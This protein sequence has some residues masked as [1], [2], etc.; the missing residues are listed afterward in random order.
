MVIQSKRVWLAGQF[1]AAQLVLSGSKIE[2]ILP[3][4]TEPVNKD[5]GDL[6]ILPGFLDIHAHGA[7]GFDTNDGEPEGL[8]HWAEKLPEEGVTAFLPTTMAQSPEVLRKALNNTASVAEEGV[9]G[10][11]IL[12]VHL[13]GPYLD[14]DYRGAQRADALA[15]PSLTE[16]KG[17]QAAAKG[18]IRYVTLAPEHDRGFSLTRYCAERNIAVGMGHSSASYEQAVMAAANGVTGMTHV[19]NG[20]S[21]F[22]HRTPGL[23][24]AALRL[25]ELYGEIICDGH[26][27]HTAALNVFFHAKGACRGIMVSDSMRA[28]G[29]PPGG[30]YTLGGQPVEVDGQGLAKIAG[31]DTLAGSTLRLNEG[32][33]ILVEEAM[34]PFAAA[35]SSCTEN[36]ARFLGID[37]RKGKLA[38]GYDA[39]LAVLEDDYSVAGAYC[40]GKCL[41]EPA[42]L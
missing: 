1:T 2:R 25:R 32:L 33:R 7:Y 22:H 26:H 3:Y 24:G 42:A 41:W 8:R 34:V 16:F 5:W 4:R 28:K 35:V 40:L 12:G 13:E 37:G 31:T 10:A 19:Y 21:G 27:C 38:A 29:C 9:C 36:P 39:D 15:K 11:E 23:A 14:P 6:R 30:G 17:Y 18:R 20:M